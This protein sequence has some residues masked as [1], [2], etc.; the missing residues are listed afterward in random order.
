MEIFTKNSAKCTVFQS[1]ICNKFSSL[2]L[3]QL[4]VSRLQLPTSCAS[5]NIIRIHHHYNGLFI[6]VRFV[7]TSSHERCGR[8]NSRHESPFSRR[9]RVNQRCRMRDH[10]LEDRVSGILMMTV[11]QV[12]TGFVG[13][14]LMGAS[15]S[16]CRPPGKTV[17]V[18]VAPDQHF[19]SQPLQSAPKHP[20]ASR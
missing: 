19:E 3:S 15:P 10:A 1:T 2:M 17:R 9:H 12:E 20:R 14:R 13:G 7:G 5:T 6:L 11:S 4:S 8:T 18:C 16:F